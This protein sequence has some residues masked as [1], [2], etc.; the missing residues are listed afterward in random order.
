MGIVVNNLIIAASQQRVM[1]EIVQHRII[2]DLGNAYDCRAVGI[3]IRSHLREHGCKML[4]FIAVNFAIII[5][6]TTRGEVIVVHY[7]IINRVIKIFKIIKATTATLYCCC[8][9]KEIAGKIK[10]GLRQFA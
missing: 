9:C 10:T 3:N 8:A 4:H 7:R 5:P 1:N 6:C 2:L